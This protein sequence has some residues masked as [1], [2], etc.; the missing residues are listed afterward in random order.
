MARKTQASTPDPQPN[1]ETSA[2]PVLEKPG[3]YNMLGH[4]EPF[5][6]PTTDVPRMHWTIGKGGG[7]KTTTLTIIYSLLASSGV[8]TMLAQ[9]A[10]MQTATDP[11]IVLFDLDVANP[12]FQ[13]Y[14]DLPSEQV[15]GTLDMFLM[16]Q[17]LQHTLLPILANGH[18]ILADLGGSGEVSSLDFIEENGLS[19]ILGESIVS[20]AMVGSLDS[21]GTAESI[22]LRAPH[23][24]MILYLNQK[25]P[26]LRMVLN[27]PAS[28]KLLDGVVALPNVLG[29]LN[30]P[31]LR[32]AFAISSRT[33]RTL[34]DATSYDKLSL[35]ERQICRAA[36]RKLEVAFAPAAA[37]MP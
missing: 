26:E 4:T 2:E 6:R 14:V 35:I 24:P 37:W 23:M 9:Q 15:C 19:E 28:R 27:D 10:R 36:L 8:A 30:L 34:H 29:A 5:R 20:H 17:L 13:R 3:P 12:S 18:S 1:A 21:I 25:E 11:S 16:G 22:A 31:D 33:F 32:A 7:G